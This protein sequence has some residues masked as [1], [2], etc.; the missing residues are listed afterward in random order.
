M[1][2]NFKKIFFICLA[3]FFLFGTG[4]ALGADYL[5]RLGVSGNSQ[6]VI[7]MIAPEGRVGAQATNWDTNFY[8][9]VKT[10]GDSTIYTQPVL[11][12]SDDR[13]KYL[14]PIDLT[15]VVSGNYNIL[16][17]GAQHLTRKMSNI[18]LSDGLNTLNFTQSD[19]STATGTVVL[20]AGDINGTGVD[21]ATLGDDV[22]N[23]VDLNIMLAVL[24]QDDLTGNTVRAN[25]NQDIVVNSVDMSL[26]LKNLDVEGDQ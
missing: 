6:A 22:I 9:T 11:A 15:G 14:T 19:N 16:I 2:I 18:S 21:P 26:L 8:L 3:L 24:D 25:L 12:A 4:Y 7:N 23:A 5:I 1:R 20:L 10:L 13:G 17:K